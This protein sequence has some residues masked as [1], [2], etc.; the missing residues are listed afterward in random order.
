M[1]SQSHQALPVR[2]SRSVGKFFDRRG[3]LLVVTGL[4]SLWMISSFLKSIIMGAIFAVVLYPFLLRLSKWRIP[5]S[6]KAGIVT[7][8]FLIGVLFPLGILVVVGS[9]SAF[10]AIQHA[11]AAAGSSNAFSVKSLSEMFRVEGLTDTFSDWLPISEAQLRQY[12]FEGLKRLGGYAADVLQ[13]LIADLPAL[14]LSVVVIL[15]TI[16][17]L[18][19]D[20]RRAL[21][22]VRANSF[23]SPNATDRILEFLHSLCYSTVVASIVTGAVQTALLCLACLIAGASN[24]LLIALVTFIFSFLPMFGT[25]PITLFLSIEAFATGDVGFGVLYLVFMG[26][27]G[28]SDNIVRPMVLRGGANL[29]PLVGFVAAFGGLE[30]IGFWGLF[31]GPVVVGLFFYILPMVTRTYR[32]QVQR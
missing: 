20:G 4:I 5:I 2:T 10:E 6:I 25:A 1:S 7:F 23:F 30:T 18:L 27:I 3:T 29:H 12:A 32:M 31:I 17:Y 13:K 28:V 24:I 22:F 26:V 9:Q 15:F 16:Y 11:Q 21:Q 8:G 14:F 19:I